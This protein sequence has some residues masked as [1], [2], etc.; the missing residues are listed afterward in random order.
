MQSWRSGKWLLDADKKALHRF[1]VPCARNALL[2]WFTE[3]RSTCPQLPITHTLLQQKACSLGDHLSMSDVFRGSI[4]F[5]TRFKERHAIVSKAVRGDIVRIRA[6]S[7]CQRVEGGGATDPARVVQPEG[8][9]QRDET[10]VF[11]RKLRALLQGRTLPR[12]KVVQEAHQC[13]GVR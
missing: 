10:G 6:P 2:D 4:G 7:G 1:Q 12:R 13:I 9:V 11:K 8:H 3:T 5:I